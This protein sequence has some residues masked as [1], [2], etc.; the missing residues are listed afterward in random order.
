MTSGINIIQSSTNWTA[1]ELCCTLEST[2]QHDSQ[3]PRHIPYVYSEDF[4]LLNR[5]P[6]S[7]SGLQATCRLFF[8]ARLRLQFRMPPV[9]GS[10]VRIRGMVRTQHFWIRTSLSS[11]AAALHATIC[12]RLPEWQTLK[13]ISS[14]SFVRIESN[15]LQHTRDTDAKMMDQNFEIR[16]L[17]FLRIF[18]NFQKGVA[19]SLCGRSGSL[20]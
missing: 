15:F 19:R 5:K 11:T 13:Y 3:C 9:H 1:T 14:V 10:V 12:G 2:T 8:T 17:W 20:W 6:H 18:W 7:L 4:S 16:I